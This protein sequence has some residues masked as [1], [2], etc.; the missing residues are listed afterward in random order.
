MAKRLKILLLPP[1]DGRS[2][3]QKYI[4]KA[5]DGQHDLSVY[6]R[7]APMEPQFVGI[8]VVID[9]GAQGIPE[10]ADIAQSV[11]LWQL[12]STGFD[13]FR[14]D[15]WRRKRIPV[16]NCPGQTSA[17]PLAECVMMLML[18]LSRRWPITQRSLCESKLHEPLG[19]ELANHYLGLIGFG[20]SGRE[21]ARRARSF[22]MRIMATDVR[23]ISKEEQQDFGLEFAGGAEDL[24][25]VIR[26][27]DYLSL[28]L[29]LNSET[30]HIINSERLRLMKP[31]ACLINVARGALVEEKALY[32]WL[33]ERR[34]GGAGLDVFSRE[35]IELNNPLLSLP[36]VVVTP[37]IAGVTEQ[38]LERRAA[39]A[40]EN[41]ARV[42]AGL[43]PL[44]R[45]DS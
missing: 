8:H 22:G 32:I 10:M 3:R 9:Y 25:H 38:T 2:E 39:C 29:H 27:S 23:R 28:H 31:T 18:L 20:A 5:I 11:Q 17:V 37:H 41:I 43:E 24:E 1:P 45:V 13:H 12:L 14:V 40:A 15:H 7:R 19:M 33:A 36:N 35:P 21:L 34:I 26:N 6:D 16:A 30:R 44:Y 42:A 4:T